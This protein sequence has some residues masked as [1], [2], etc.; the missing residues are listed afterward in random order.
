MDE[1]ARRRKERGGIQTENSCLV[2]ERCR[3]E[4]MVGVVGDA[5]LTGRAGIGKAE[6]ITPTGR[7]CSI[8]HGWHG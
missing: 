7:Q 8:C 3:F 5:R 2:I 1:G 4:R 6:A